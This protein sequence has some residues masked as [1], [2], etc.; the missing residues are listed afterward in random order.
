MSNTQSIR[1]A[2]AA[3][4]GIEFRNPLPGHEID[5]VAYTADMGA[6]VELFDNLC[7]NLAAI[8]AI[9]QRPAHLPPVV[10][11]DV[12]YVVGDLRVRVT[13]AGG[14]HSA[15]MLGVTAQPDWTR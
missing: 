1:N 4:A 3:I 11:H 12:S 15:P 5:A 13:V 2:V 8:G 6:A 10:G 14:T 7:A 9:V